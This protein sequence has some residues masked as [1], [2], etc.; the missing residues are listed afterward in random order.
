MMSREIKYLPCSIV[1]H[2][3]CELILAKQIQ[4]KM[5]RNLH[6][7]AKDNGRNSILINTLNYYLQKL[8]PN[9][10]TYIRKNRDFL[11]YDKNNDKILNHKIF[12]I[13]DKDETS[14]QMFQSYI[15]KSMFKD[16]WWGK[17]ELIEPIFFNP[18]MDDVLKKHGINIDTKNHKPSQYFKLLTTK[19]E[20]IISILK[21]LNE[22]E[23]NIKL[24]FDYLENI[25]IKLNNL[26][27]NRL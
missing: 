22:K 15:D 7:L 3:E 27:K 8:Y 25:E 23:S 1:C 11:L 6:P 14:D 24:L 17:D 20:Q 9:K 10:K 16:Y 26:A 13:M 19:Y 12:A 2:G 4:A 21:E 18:N 5:R